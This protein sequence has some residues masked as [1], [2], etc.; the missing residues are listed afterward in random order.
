M[1]G[2]IGKGPIAVIVVQGVFASG[3]SAG[4]AVN[5]NSLPGAGGVLPGH[6]GVL[7]IETDVVG[8]EEIEMAVPVVVEKGTA[9]APAG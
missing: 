6:R 4:A 2:D 8:D 9:C 3:Q 7:Q 1:P 5:R